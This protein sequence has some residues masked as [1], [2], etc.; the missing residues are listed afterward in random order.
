MAS[1]KRG[2]WDLLTSPFENFAFS[3]K[4]FRL[5]RWLYCLMYG[6]L[7][8]LLSCL[9]STVRAEENGVDNNQGD[10][11]SDRGKRGRGRGEMVA[12]VWDWHCFHVLKWNSPVYFFKRFLLSI[13]WLSFDSISTSATLNLGTSYSLTLYHFFVLEQLKKNWHASLLW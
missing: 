4:G 8:L 10:R 13:F 11:P 5:S 1:K 2:N 9:L 7:K 3:F 6:S 12:L